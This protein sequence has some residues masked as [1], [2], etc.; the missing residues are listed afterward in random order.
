[1][2]ATTTD[3]REKGVSE[4]TVNTGTRSIALV[5][6]L[7]LAVFVGGFGVWA[8]TAPLSG[9]A[10]VSGV[11]AAAGK[12]QLVQHLEGGI[13]REVLV[14][15]GDRVAAGE[16][17]FVFDDTRA[18]A[19]LNAL[20]KQWVGLRARKARLEAQRDDATDV[21][22]DADLVAAAGDAGLQDLLEEQRNEFKARVALTSSETT[23]LGQRVEAGEEAIIGLEARRKALEDQLA[24]VSDEAQRKNRLLD[25]G[26]TNR[27]EYTALL[28]AQAELVGQI[29]AIASQI[30]QTRTQVEGSREQLVYKRSERVEQALTE[31]NDISARA[32][33][34][35]EKL[36]ASRDVI[37]RLVVRAPFDGLVV[38]I[39]RTTP[40]SVIAPGGELAV[41]LP[42][43]S[44]L[45]VEARVRPA[46]IDVVRPG[47]S[48]ELRFPALNAR[49]T[50]EVAGT[51]TF[52]SPDRLVDTDNRQSYYVARLRMTGD[53]PPQLDRAQIYPGMPVEAFVATGRR[54]F[55]EYLARPLLDSFNRAFREQ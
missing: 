18:R 32:A 25:Q 5:G 20:T 51:V 49:R 42:T 41:L 36:K 24:V 30:E 53:L 55:F 22:F 47:Q 19:S 13:L 52:V 3:P 27:S 28:R 33:E 15:E 1:M 9:A 14:H 16:P 29:G 2:S 38:S 40:G 44:E 23:M 46:D 10:I 43:S 21:S 34:I 7:A 50:P 39:A 26:L 8:A 48:A 11:V 54:T 31:L 37:D 6:Y 4:A 35:E 12:N 45:I 17:L